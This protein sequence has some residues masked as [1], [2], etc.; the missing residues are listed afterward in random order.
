ME[1]RPPKQARTRHPLDRSG[2]LGPLGPVPRDE[3]TGSQPTIT[4]AGAFPPFGQDELV[5]SRTRRRRALARTVLAFL[6]LV[7]ALGTLGVVYGDDAATWVDDRVDD[8]LDRGDDDDGGG[9]APVAQVSPG[10]SLSS[11]GAATPT[12][13]APPTT[14]PLP[15]PSGAPP[16]A[17]PS[18][19]A[20]PSPNPSPPASSAPS[21]APAEP[22]EPVPPIEDLLP[23]VEDVPAGWVSTVDGDRPEAEVA[24]SFGDPD[25]AATKLEAW[26]WRQ[27]LYITFE[28]PNADLATDATNYL[29]VSIHRF[30]DA[31]AAAEALPYFA[32]AVVAAQGLSAIEVDPV[33]DAVRALR[34]N[35]EGT[36]NLV[37]VY[38]QD[39]PFLIRIGGS[40]PTGDPTDDALALARLIA[41]R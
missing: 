12:S 13:A 23:T 21:E 37:V 15:S 16:A 30:R 22:A 39:G 25:D 24:G 35:P 19:A 18:T 20:E 6:A 14:A 38:A 33:G 8:A 36:A 32:D 10:P 4:T 34:G 3:A 26:G 29:A 5:P 17:A 31:A 41:E 2:G 1:P 28:D 27:N 7:A 9:D 40:S 11:A